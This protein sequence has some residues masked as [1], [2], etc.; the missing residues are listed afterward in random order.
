ML[1]AR[2]V[3]QDASFRTKRIKNIVTRTGPAPVINSQ[4][5]LAEKG[6]LCCLGRCPD[7][8]CVYCSNNYP[9]ESIRIITNGKTGDTTATVMGTRQLD[10]TIRFDLFTLSGCVSYPWCTQTVSWN[11]VLPSGFTKEPV[12]LTCGKASIID[13]SPVINTYPKSVNACIAGGSDTHNPAPIV[14]QSGSGG[15]CNTITFTLLYPN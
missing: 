5:W 3:S 9:C 12:N 2:S 4:G 8:I 15:P 14:C 11:I 6:P 13:T 7:A 1:G 10:G